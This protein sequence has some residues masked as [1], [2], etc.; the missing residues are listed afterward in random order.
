MCKHSVLK[1]DGPS[2]RL[3][4]TRSS[5]LELYGI[6]A[7]DLPLLKSERVQLS[8]LILPPASN[9][10]LQ[11]LLM[12][13]IGENL[14]LI[15]LRFV[16]CKLVREPYKKCLILRVTTSRLHARKSFSRPSQRKSNDT[17]YLPINI[18]LKEIGNKSSGLTSTMSG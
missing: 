1:Q 9:L 16:V 17:L 6:S 12:L 13:S 11:P 5:V 14:S 10:F 2:S 8:N 3:Q 7:M 4:I 18:E 15:L